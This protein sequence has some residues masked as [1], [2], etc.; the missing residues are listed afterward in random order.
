M[1]P[2][3]STRGTAMPTISDYLD[4]NSDPMTAADGFLRG[5]PGAAWRAAQTIGQF[6]GGLGDAEAWMSKTAQIGAW[7][8]QFGSMLGALGPMVQNH[9]R[10]NPQTLGTLYQAMPGLVPGIAGTAGGLGV[11]GLTDLLA[12]GGRNFAT[13]LGM[14]QPAARAAAPAPTPTPPVAPDFGPGTPDPPGVLD[15]LPGLPAPPPGTR[16][17]ANPTTAPSNPWMTFG[18]H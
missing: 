14:N 8:N 4:A 13:L 12:H 3:E 5:D 9:L 11:M 2:D 10:S 7:M 6:E 15:G 16:V 18:G 1:D 17:R